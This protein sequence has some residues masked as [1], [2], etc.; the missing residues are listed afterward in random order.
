MS[1]HDVATGVFPGAGILARE[2]WVCWRA[3]VEHASLPSA[4]ARYVLLALLLQF[5]TNS[6]EY[7]HSDRV[8]PMWTEIARR[9]AREWARQGFGEGAATGG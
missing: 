9:Y 7:A 3:A 6:T 5:A 4:A 8:R 1:R 2:T